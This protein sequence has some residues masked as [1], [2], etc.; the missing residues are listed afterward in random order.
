M[1]DATALLPAPGDE[2]EPGTARQLEGALRAVSRPRFLRR[3][4]EGEIA[5][6]ELAGLDAEQ[7][8]AAYQA[9]AILLDEGGSAFPLPAPLPSVAGIRMKQLVEEPA[10]ASEWCVRI[11]QL[12]ARQLEGPGWGSGRA[13]ANSVWGSCEVALR[14]A[15]TSRLAADIEY[16]RA[17]LPTGR[18]A[19][20]AG[21]IL[22][23]LRSFG[24]RLSPEQRARVPEFWQKPI[25]GPDE[26]PG[27]GEYWWSLQ[28]LRATRCSVVDL[29]DPEA[30]RARIDAA[31]DQTCRDLRKRWSRLSILGPPGWG[32]ERGVWDSA[33]PETWAEEMEGRLNELSQLART[34]STPVSK[35]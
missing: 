32:C 29:A 25:A 4:A 12:A 34:A 1:A 11:L 30:R 16:L 33:R 23:E 7:Y 3:I 35:E 17:T 21:W 20:C 13:L 2:L 9:L 18:E 10:A 5:L 31:L 26:L 22:E 27:A 8:E 28:Q 19:V 15:G 6:S 24:S 14:Q